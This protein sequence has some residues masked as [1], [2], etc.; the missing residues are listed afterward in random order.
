METS[1][2]KVVGIWF[3]KSYPLLSSCI[4]Y[5]AQLFGNESLDWST[6]DREVYKKELGIL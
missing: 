1:T 6:V 3:F 4:Q 5:Q 2:G